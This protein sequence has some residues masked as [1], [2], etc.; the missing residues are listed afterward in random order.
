[1]SAISDELKNKIRRQA[2]NRC[3]YCLTP[4]AIVSM[5]L[6]IEHLQPIACGGTDDEENLW[7]ACRNCNGFKHAKTHATDPQTN[8]ETPL[9]NPRQ[10]VWSEHFELSEDKTEIVGKTACGRATIIAL[11][12]N[13][14]QAVNA[15]KVW[16]S[17]GWFP[18]QD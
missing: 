9:F 1:M 5:P 2:R 17:A 3:G 11:R 10:Q 6:E 7:L 16:V 12:L 8:I 4:Q 18:P 14:E 13:F 15:R